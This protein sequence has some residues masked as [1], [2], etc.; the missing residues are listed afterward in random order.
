MGREWGEQI[1]RCEHH[2][3]SPADRLSAN[4][5]VGASYVHLRIRAIDLMAPGAVL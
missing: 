3:A 5:Q 2:A 1:D 4:G